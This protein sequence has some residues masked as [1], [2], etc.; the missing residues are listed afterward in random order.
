MNAS[1]YVR[2]ESGIDDGITTARAIPNLA[3]RTRRVTV[4][5]DE[6]RGQLE[7]ASWTKVERHLW[8]S[9]RNPVPS[10]LMPGILL[11]TR[12]LSAESSAAPA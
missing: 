2:I 7:M 5:D 9:I 1:V 10:K 3:W 4:R 6:P 11:Q 12:I 8:Q